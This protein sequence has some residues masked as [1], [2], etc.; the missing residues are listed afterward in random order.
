MKK[1]ITAQS[2]RKTNVLAGILHLGQMIAVLAL[3]NDF[4]L[5]ITAT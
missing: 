3:S 2:L 1:P 5:P 4:A